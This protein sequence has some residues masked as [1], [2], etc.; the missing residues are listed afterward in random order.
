MAADE[1]IRQLPRA[2]AP[3]STDARTQ[4]T[5][6]SEEVY[7]ELLS[8][9]LSSRMSPGDRITIDALA[10]EL[11]VSQTPIREA[12]NRLSADGIVVRAHLA[13]YRVASKLDRQQFEDLV[14]L[15]LLLEPL[16][17]RKA[18]EHMT[19]AQL[20]ELNEIAERMRNHLSETGSDRGYASFSQRDADFHDKVAEGAGNVY[21]RESLVRLHT[22]VHLF[23]LSNDDL[24]TALA[25][26]EHAAII[27]AVRRRDPDAAAYAMRRHIE[28]SAQRFRAAFTAD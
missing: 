23:R 11:D 22:H 16:A 13:G 7:A 25:I 15:R 5:P 26:D 3:R 24:I 19:P 21:V 28:A 1:S 27:D 20:Q 12:L 17:A 10:R 2:S 8:R 18:A 14:E 6:I 9:I 4:R